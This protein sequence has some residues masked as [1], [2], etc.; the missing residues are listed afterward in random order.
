ML[1]S[2]PLIVGYSQSARGVTPRYLYSSCARGTCQEGRTASNCPWTMA[3]LVEK[4]SGLGKETAL[5][6]GGCMRSIRGLTG[7][8]LR[9]FVTKGEPNISK[10]KVPVASRCPTNFPQSPSLLSPPSPLPSS[11]KVAWPDTRLLGINLSQSLR[12]FY[13]IRR[14]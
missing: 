4:V 11:K 3:D 9:L 14:R 6:E 5:D 1:T 12:G 13:P 7:G 8:G 10:L 2:A